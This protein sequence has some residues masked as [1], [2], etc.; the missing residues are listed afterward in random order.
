[1]TVLAKLISGFLVCSCH[2]IGN[3]G[4]WEVTVELYHVKSVESF[5]YL[6]FSPFIL[7]SQYSL[8][9]MVFSVL[10]MIAANQQE[11]W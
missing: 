4:Y 11:I 6:F 9:I 3:I 8:E 5:F 2:L 1:M 7:F 10:S